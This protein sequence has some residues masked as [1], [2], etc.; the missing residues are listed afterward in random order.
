MKQ[1]NALTTSLIIFF[2]AIALEAAAQPP[3]NF[4]V[5]AYFFGK[6]QYAIDSV[7]VEKL[8]HIIY[9]FCHLSGNVL[10]VDNSDGASTI[11]NLVALKK[12]NPSLKVLLSLGGWGGCKTCADVFATDKGRKEFAQSVLQL[13][14]FFKTDGIDIDWEYPVVE[15]YPG[16]KFGPEDKQNFTA[17]ILELRKTLGSEYEISF[18]AGGFQK[19]LEE[20]VDWKAVTP[21]VDRINMMTYDLVNG[22]STVTGHHTPLYSNA[23]QKESTDNAIKYLIR[24]G[25]PANKLVIGAGFYGRIWENVEP[26]RD[27]LYQSGKFKRG[28][29]FEEFGSELTAA[30][31]WKTFWDNTANAPY[32]YN[33]GQKLF[34][35]YDDRKSMDLKTKYTIDNKLNGIMFWEINN[36]TYSG[37]LLDAIDKAKK[38]YKPK[39]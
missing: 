4:T 39:K 13:N 28:L 30:K 10:Q 8:T 16:H 14:Q 6:P 24:M 1:Y 3:N 20:A 25:V 2:I 34:I 23:D 26:T 12:R 33:S 36:D 9:S 11:T 17:L 27:G 37:G 32:A 19:F 7:A 29:D 15:G 18:A 35:T 5:T 22:N 38:T 21:A 31:G